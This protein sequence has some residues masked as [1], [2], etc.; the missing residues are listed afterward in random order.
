MPEGTR[1]G[2]SVTSALRTKAVFGDDVDLFRP[3]RWI[4]ADQ[5]T[6]FKMEQTALLAFGFGRW[7]CAG[8][9][10]AFM[11]LNKVYVEVS[12][13]YFDI[14]S[15]PSSFCSCRW[16]NLCEFLQLLRRFD[17]QLVYPKNP[18]STK[19]H[20]MYVQKNLWV[21]VSERD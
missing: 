16:A 15:S 11:E 8:K 17:F 9:P 6:K 2:H 12:K 5:A 21:R 13:I 7:G 10:V 18:L 19:E 1:I 20:N 3:E 14:P 4:E